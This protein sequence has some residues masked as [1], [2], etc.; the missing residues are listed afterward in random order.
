[1]RA[2][3][4]SCSMITLEEEGDGCP[5]PLARCNNVVDTLTLL[6]VLCEAPRDEDGPEGYPPQI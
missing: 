1:M 6:T 2:A 5:V 3:R 4:I